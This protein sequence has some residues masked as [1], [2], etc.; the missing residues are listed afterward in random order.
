MMLQPREGDQFSDVVEISMPSLLVEVGT[1]HGASLVRFMQCAEAAGLNARAIAIDTW[2][3]SVEHWTDQLR[4]EWAR[5]ELRLSGMEPQFI[6]AF[7]ANL[8]EFGLT[9]RVSILRAQSE[10]GLTFLN[11]MGTRAD[12]VYVDGD[13][14]FAAVRSD[15]QLSK[16]LVRDKRRGFVAGDDWAWAGVR[17]A[18]IASA[19]QM[20][21]SIWVKNGMW[22]LLERGA[23]TATEFRRRGWKWVSPLFIPWHLVDPRSAS[24]RRKRLKRR[25]QRRLMDP[26]FVWLRRLRG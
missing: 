16:H 3:G 2:L 6:E 5:S 20:G 23:D 12:L 26:L 18:V 13:H 19:A 14:S 9:D 15:I 1:W 24:Y 7:R 4:G 21:Q 17:R 8:K 11:Q 25:I 10:A 22:V